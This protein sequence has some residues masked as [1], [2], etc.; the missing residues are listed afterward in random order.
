[1]RDKTLV[2][3]AVGLMPKFDPTGNHLVYSVYGPYDGPYW[4]LRR[5]DVRTGRVTDLNTDPDH[6][7]VHPVW[8][9]DG[10]KVVAQEGAVEWEGLPRKVS[11]LD[12]ATGTPRRTILTGSDT[13][14]IVPRDWRAAS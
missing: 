7:T 5:I 3:T 12:A 4:D 11:I 10:T 6:A 9:S 1:M 14:R 2:R 8:S 13:R